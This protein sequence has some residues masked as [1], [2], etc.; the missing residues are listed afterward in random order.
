MIP[1][2]LLHQQSGHYLAG[3]NLLLAHA[4]TVKLYRTKYKM[5]QGGQIGITINSDYKQFACDTP[6]DRAAA[7]RAQIFVMGW[8]ADPVFFGK[9]VLMI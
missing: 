3:H 9:Y 4:K 5:K 8:F 6:Q 7:E 1:P 2:S